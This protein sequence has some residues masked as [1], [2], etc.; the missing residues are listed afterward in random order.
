M[1]F[2]LHAGFQPT[3]SRQ[4][5]DGWKRSATA[6]KR[7]RAVCV[8]GARCT[9]RNRYLRRRILRHR[10]QR[11]RLVHLAPGKHSTTEPPMQTILKQITLVL[12]YTYS[13]IT[14]LPNM[15]VI[16]VVLTGR[17][18]VGSDEH[19]MPLSDDTCRYTHGTI[20]NCPNGLQSLVW[21]LLIYSCYKIKQKHKYKSR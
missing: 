20:S 18:V 7:T 10:K 13:G 11:L 12:Q 14:N 8:P 9:N 1:M 2:L 21:N 3:L 5:S 4:L 17:S 15:V 19:F 16:S 6:G